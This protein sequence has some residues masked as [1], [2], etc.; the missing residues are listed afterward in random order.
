MRVTLEDNSALQG[1]TSFPHPKV[2]TK[3]GRRAG[4]RVT[5]AIVHPQD[6]CYAR[7]SVEG[8]KQVA[9]IGVGLLGGSL[10]LAIRSAGLAERVVGLA[11]RPE[12]RRI[13]CEIGAADDCTAEISEAVSCADLVVL[14]TPLGQMK[15][16]AQEMAPF[17]KPGAWVTDVGSVKASVVR[18]LE[19]LMAS[20][21][22]H[23]VG[24]HPM[25]GSEQNGVENSTVDLFMN[26]VTILTPTDRT[27][28][29]TLEG[30][31]SFWERLQSSVCIM[32]AQV[33]DRLVARSSHLP[34]AVAAS[35]A[36]C[37]LQPGQQPDPA[38]L[39]A[40]GFRDTTRVAS[41]SR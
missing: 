23:F 29:G 20:T 39:C 32:E 41:E 5:G 14:C 17:L 8:L 19:P 11:R 21:G 28:P 6:S 31:R 24:G 26:A 9:I 7:L 37:V 27:D 10:G 2:S 36:H 15:R 38:R 13:A 35:L 25:A 3:G 22:A 1:R 16:L 30:V 34:H 33:H 18:D 4:H 40:T 12:T